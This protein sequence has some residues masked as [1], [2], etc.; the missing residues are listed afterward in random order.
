MRSRNI[1]KIYLAWRQ[2]KH[3]RRIIVG[4][5]YYNKGTYIFKYITDGVKEAAALGFVNYPDFPIIDKVYSDNVL[6]VFSQR[7]YDFSR[8]DSDEYFEF[9]DIDPKY[10]DDKFYLLA[11]TQGLLNT[12]NFEFLA[13]YH[14]RKGLSFMSEI[15]NI[16]RNKLSPNLL[17]VGDVLNWKKEPDNKYDKNAVIVYKDSTEIGYIKRVHNL[18]FYD[19]RAESLIITIKDIESHETVTSAFINIKTTL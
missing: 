3:E 18:V 7:L 1:S 14:L 16:S 12:D 15:A 8:T 10:K 5:L 11:Q 13:S 17:K 9:W 4:E 2:A 6:D 19:P